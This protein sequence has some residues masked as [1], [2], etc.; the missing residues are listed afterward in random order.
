VG[1]LIHLAD[2]RRPAP[3]A[4]DYSP[5]GGPV[6]SGVC[7]ALITRRAG[8][9]TWEQVCAG[10][11]AYQHGRWVHVDACKNCYTTPGQGCLTLLDHAGCPDPEPLGCRHH[12]CTE[13]ADIDLPC[14]NGGTGE[15][16]GC[17]WTDTTRRQRWA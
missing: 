7:T 13:P 16:C 3:T 9:R 5:A 17:C 1:E 14:T 11:L 12:T 10:L 6:I 8:H 2:R 4:V 15:C